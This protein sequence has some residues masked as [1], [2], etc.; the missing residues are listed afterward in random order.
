M[1]SEI[2]VHSSEDPIQSLTSTPPQHPS[3]PPSFQQRELFDGEHSN[4]TLHGSY[5]LTLNLATGIIPLIGIGTS[6]ETTIGAAA[7]ALLNKTVLTAFN[8]RLHGGGQGTD[9]EAEEDDELGEKH[10]G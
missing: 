10:I 9:G 6:D 2:H 7:G 4:R 1:L 8:S 5:Q 3:H